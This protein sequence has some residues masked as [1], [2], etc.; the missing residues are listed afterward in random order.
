MW[1][2]GQYTYPLDLAYADSLPACRRRLIGNSYGGRCAARRF[3]SA[4]R[5]SR[6]RVD[7]TR[8][9]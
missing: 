6:S 4:D 1:G 9:N 2:S 5:K 8:L 3:N 7:S